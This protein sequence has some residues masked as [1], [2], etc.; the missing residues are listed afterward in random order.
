[1]VDFG[2]IQELAL[3]AHDSAMKAVAAKHARK[4]WHHLQS[5]ADEV[6]SALL[7]AMIPTD[8][9]ALLATPPMKRV[10]FVQTNL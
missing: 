4:P 10:F 5:T 7:E 1:V 2:R 6:A 8:V 9:Q 3:K